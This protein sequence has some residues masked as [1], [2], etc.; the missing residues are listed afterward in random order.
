MPAFGPRIPPTRRYLTRFIKFHIQLSSA[1]SRAQTR[2]ALSPPFYF[3]GL[4]NKVFEDGIV[5]MDGKLAQLFD[6]DGK[7]VAKAMMKLTGMDPGQTLDLGRVSLEVTHA[8]AASE[9]ASGRVFSAGNATSSVALTTVLPRPA[10]KPLGS[11][12]TNKLFASSGGGMAPFK[13]P[14]SLSTGGGGGVASL[15]PRLGGLV[16][17]KGVAAA[18]APSSSSAATGDDA[19]GEGASASNPSSAGSSGLSLGAFKPPTMTSLAVGGGY[20]LVGFGRGGAGGGY[21]S[22]SGG[23]K[24]RHDPNGPDAL[25]LYW[26]PGWPGGPSSSSSSSSSSAFSAGAG[27]GK[28]PA[29]QIPVVMDPHLGKCLREHQRLG[30]QFLYDCITGRASDA[31]TGCILADD[32]GLGA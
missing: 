25:V 10:L 7:V 4:Q 24:P 32:M 8:V 11:G 3:A 20:S 1:Q 29:S 21:G 26:P 17:T 18:A 9:F 30:V 5:S 28:N 27:G 23:P 31:G 12:I 6:L 16:P 14:A 13:P 15:K 2:S 22:I 19:D